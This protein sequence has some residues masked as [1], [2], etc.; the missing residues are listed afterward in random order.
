MRRQFSHAERDTHQRGA[1]NSPQ[2]R[3]RYL[4]RLQGYRQEQ[5]AQRHQRAGGEKVAEHQGVGFR[6]GQHQPGIAK[7]EDGDKQADGGRQSQLDRLRHRAGDHFAQAKAG[8]QE[9]E[10]PR[11]AGNSE[12]SLPANPFAT[13]QRHPHQHRAANARADDKRQV[14]IKRHQQRA[15]DEDQNGAGGGGAF[16]HPADRQQP[17]DDHQ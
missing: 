4:T 15:D 10:D 8:Q 14:G 1:Q 3:A 12:A 2:N 7:T 6:I 16:I 9:E 13:G 17:R 11:P 5:A